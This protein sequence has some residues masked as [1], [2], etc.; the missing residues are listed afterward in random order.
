RPR[1]VRPPARFGIAPRA[2][3]GWLRPRPTARR[4]PNARR[5][6]K[7]R[8][9]TERAAMALERPEIDFPGGPPTPY[10]DVTDLVEGD[11]P[12]AVKGSTV[13]VHY[14]GVAYSTG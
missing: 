7:R 13:S 5:A 8:K 10:L 4:P 1:A 14:V 12:E 11:G 2:P 9:K 3:I 6:T